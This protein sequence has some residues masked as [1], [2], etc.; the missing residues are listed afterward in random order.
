MACATAAAAAADASGTAASA[1]SFPQRPL[2]LVVPFTSGGTADLMGRFVAQELATRF[3]QTVVVDNRAGAGATLGSDLVAKAIADGYTLLVSNAAS[4]AV[5]PSLYRKMPYDAQA[6][7]AHVALIGVTPQL[8]VVNNAQPARSLRAFISDAKRQPGRLHFGTAGVGSIGHFAGELL[9]RSAGIDLVHVAY[10]GTAPATTD[11]VGNRV[12]AMF[13]NPP[14]AA[15]HVRAGTFRLLAATG[16]RRAP[17]FPETPTFIEEGVAGFVTFTWYGVSAPRGT[18][19]A[20]VARLHQAITEALG[21]G[22]LGA[23]L[24]ELGVEHRPY[25]PAAFTA[26]VGAEVERF[27]RIAADAG[28]RPES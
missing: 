7:F 19:A 24:A 8:F 25:S 5:A 14:E 22:P 10:R 21:S 28:I 13:Q 26:F 2:R 9:K 15:P 16:D 11:L 3:G 17:L 20:V 27:R 12:Q 4:H 23:R 6:D 18:P 1:R